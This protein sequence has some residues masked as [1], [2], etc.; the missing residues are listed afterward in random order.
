MTDYIMRFVRV[1][2]YYEYRY[3]GSTKVGYSCTPFHD[4]Y[5]G[6]GTT[7]ADEGSRQKELVA[8]QPRIEAWR[9]TKGYKLHVKVSAMR[10]DLGREAT[11]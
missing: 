8:N 10:F 1:A 2:A 3:R 9:R 6:Q 5:L 7:F 4:E 11:S